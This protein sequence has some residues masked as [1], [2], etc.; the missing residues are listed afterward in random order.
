MSTN[1]KSYV[2]GDA[3]G[4]I[5]FHKLNS[6]NFPI[7]ATLTKDDYVIVCGDFGAIWD[8][9]G[10]DRYLQNWYTEKPWTTLFVD[11]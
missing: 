3:H 8:G 10:Q 6:K 2:T 1:S 9:A 4:D 7:G 5:D 11:G